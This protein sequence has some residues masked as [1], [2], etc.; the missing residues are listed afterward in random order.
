MIKIKDMFRGLFFTLFPPICSVCS[1]KLKENEQFICSYCI[2]DMP[3]TYNWRITK[4]S[5][6]MRINNIAEIEGSASLFYYNL[7]DNYKN[8]ILDSKFRNQRNLAIE[9]GR[10]MAFFFESNEKLKCVDLIIP[11]PLHSTRKIWRGYNQSEFICR[12][13]SEVL[14]IPLNTNTVIRHKKSKTQSRLK[15]N[16]LRQENVKD[17]F[18]VIDVSILENKSILLVD[19]V[20]T[21]GA[22]ISSCIKAIKKAVPT[23]KVYACSTSSVE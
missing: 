19:D 12:G 11:I 21:T 23:C 10:W 20:I 16:S 5:L 18:S 3:L 8:L 17:A 7:N 2:E 1:K 4:D 22:T 14:N 15:D 9:L 13:L 6:F